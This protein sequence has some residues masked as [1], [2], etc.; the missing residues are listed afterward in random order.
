M[1]SLTKFYKNSLILIALVLISYPV[2]LYAQRAGSGNIQKIERQLPAF[3]KIEVGSAFTVVLEQGE[4]MVMV[5]TDDNLADKIETM[6]SNGTLHINSAGIKN[7]TSMKVHIASPNLSE[8]NIS[9]A[10]RVQ[11]KGILEYPSLTVNASGASRANLELRSQDLV[12]NVAGA[13]RLTLRGEATKHSSGISGASSVNA[14]MLK[15]TTTTTEISGAGKMSAFAKTQINAN[16]RDA[17]SLSYFDNSTVKK[18]KTSGS[19][20]IN[21]NNPDNAVPTNSDDSLAND[22]EIRVF[23][24]GDSTF[25]KLKDLNVRI[26]DEMEKVDI[27]MG[28]HKI[29]V[30]GDGN[31]KLKKEKK[32]AF[33]GHWGGIDLGINGFSFGDFNDTPPAGYEFLDL[34]M[35]KSINFAL[36]LFEQ[37]FN[38][39][40]NKFGLVTGLGLEWN[41]YRFRNNVIINL[42]EDLVGMRDND[43]D[44]FYKKSKLVT[45]YLTL[46]VMF[47]F[48]T[49][50]YS[51]ANSFHIAAGVLS[52]L[53]ISTH[54]KLKYET[55][56]TKTDKNHGAPS[57]N[58]FKLDAMARIGWGK[59]NIYGKYS[60]IELFKKNRGPE[61]Y[62]YSVGIT[63]LNW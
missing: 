31:V 8:I 7:P 59:I 19:S 30:D 53:R 21:L 57:M 63:L 44:K 3:N 62:P 42:D 52:G 17:G 32:E 15:T 4:P 28:R 10:A 48:Q 27:A 56:N 13:S 46:P 61:I 11:S 50:S 35:E 58:P 55:N 47:E 49:N 25:V 2:A 18:L 9:G 45:T 1:E 16:L 43:P 23:E 38:I 60:L 51:K 37:D 34:R 22:I 29:E 36:N 14:L 6:V 26:N 12:T 5:E 24:D 54:T 20:V 41:N 40:D 33:D 39:I